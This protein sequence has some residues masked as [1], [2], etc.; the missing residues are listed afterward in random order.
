MRQERIVQDISSL[1]TYA[2]GSRVTMWWGTLGFCALEG[3]GFAIAVA[4]YLYLMQ[5]N[6]EWP[7][8]A[9]P[10]G[11]W[12]GTIISILLLMSLV[13]NQMIK[14]RARMEDLPSVQ[15][16]LIV[17]SGIGLLAVAMRFYE[18]RHLNVGWDDNAYG[19]ILWI[20]LGLHATH[21][22]TDLGDT[23]VLTALMFTRHA[24]GKRFSDTE[25]NAFYWDFVVLSWLPLYVL[26]YWVPRW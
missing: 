6:N 9:P 25:D 17:M 8:S 16:F 4:T 22:I 14:R 1:P 23:L 20:I 21:L 5:T 18:F 12:P 15:K 13:P 11:Y 24:H 2:F 3:T 19:S 7:L 26:I 10:P